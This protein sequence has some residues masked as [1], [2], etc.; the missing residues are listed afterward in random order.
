[1]INR[2]GAE[3]QMG[4]T[5]SELQEYV[6]KRA[7]EFLDREERFERFA[8]SQG[9]RMIRGQLGSWASLVRYLGRWA[10]K[11]EV[12]RTFESLVHLII[13]EQLIQ[14]CSLE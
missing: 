8:I 12:D 13:R 7:K 11:A 6:E 2:Y 5:G 3:E 14:T 1:M 9:W 10:E 4:L